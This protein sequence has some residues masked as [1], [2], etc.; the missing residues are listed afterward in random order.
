MAPNEAL[1][2]PDGLLYCM[3]VREERRKER[4]WVR[5][6]AQSVTMRT[7]VPSQH[8]GVTLKAC[9]KTWMTAHEVEALDQNDLA[10]RAGLRVGDLLVALNGEPMPPGAEAAVG[11]MSGQQ[12]LEVPMA[13]PC[14]HRSAMC[15]SQQIAWS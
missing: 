10:W 3:Q 14:A 4:R 13:A 1:M 12:L 9:A 5:E 15:P 8:L 7:N 11:M 2:T 6:H